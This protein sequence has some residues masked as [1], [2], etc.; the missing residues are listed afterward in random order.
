MLDNLLLG[1]ATAVTV[2]NIAVMLF[3]TVVGLWIGVLPG[4]GATSAMAILIPFTFSMSPLAALLMLASIS[5]AGAF[6]GSITSILLN[7][8]GDA[9]SAAT[10]YDGYPLAQQG[11]ARVA[12]G[13]SVGASL[14]GG[15]VGVVLLTTLSQP[16]A[17]VALAFGPADHF[18]LGILGLTIVAVASSGD[19][20][21]G[22][23]MGCVGIVVS[24]VGQDAVLGH[25]RYAFGSIYLEA[26]IDF[27]T[28]TIGL[29]AITEIIFMM[30]SGGTIARGGKLEG[31]LWEGLVDTLRYPRALWG[32]IGVGAIIG[33]IPGVGATAANFLSYSIAHRTSRRPEL[34]GKGSPEGVIAPEASNNSCIPTSFIP[35]LTLGIPGGATAAILLVAVTIHGIRPGPLLFQANADLVYGFFAGLMIA[36]IMAAV[37]CVVM[38][39]WFALVTVVRVEIMAPILI[40]VSLAGAYGVQ[41]SVA[42]VFVAIGFGVFGYVARRNGYPLISLIIGLILGQ[43]VEKSFHQALVLSDGDYLTFFVRPISGVVLTACILMV[44]LPGMKRRFRGG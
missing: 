39:P 1:L 17:E 16:I 13:L 44:V 42:D 3:G 32:S 20:L 18:A 27:V 12:M 9:S 34:F 24:F 38:I 31:S 29:F 41:R 26:G 11:R 25:T 28:V 7:I 2:E 22:L 8:P 21:K 23:I 5:V 10:A 37:L 30:T 4:L 36:T 14:V 19:T 15:L 33:I 35:A 43:L 40:A 6:G